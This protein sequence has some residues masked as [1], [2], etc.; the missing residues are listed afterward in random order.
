MRFKLRLSK[1]LKDYKKEIKKLDN[2]NPAD[3]EVI[4][5]VREK[6]YLKAKPVIDHLELRGLDASKVA[7]ELLRLYNSNKDILVRALIIGIIWI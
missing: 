3:K 4:D 6:S 7:D 5:I 2:K 1:M